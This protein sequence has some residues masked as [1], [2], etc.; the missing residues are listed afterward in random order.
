MGK[1][2]KGDT[3]ESCERAIDVALGAVQSGFREVAATVARVRDGELWRQG[4]YK[5]LAEW[6]KKKYGWSRQRGQQMASAHAI[7]LALPEN[8]TTMVVNE[9]QV[10]AIVAVPAEKRVNVLDRAVAKGEVTARS[11][12]IAAIEDAIKS[13][14]LVVGDPAP[15]LNA[16]TGGNIIEETE[17]VIFEPAELDRL[18]GANE[19]PAVRNECLGCQAKD[20]ELRTVWSQVSERDARI[21]IL[22]SLLAAANEGEIPMDDPIVEVLP[23]NVGALKNLIAGIESGR[24]SEE[25]R[26]SDAPKNCSCKH[27]G[28]RFAGARFATLCGRCRDNGHQERQPEDCRECQSAFA[29]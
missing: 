13:G 1:L 3:L 8:L 10:R 18:A 4:G 16:M 29:A 27:C 2:V 20:N 14:D 11:I 9:R 17:T 12:E 23:P 25:A 22:E 19:V 5:N 26:T 28:D 7:L 15:M 21:E 24:S 6:G